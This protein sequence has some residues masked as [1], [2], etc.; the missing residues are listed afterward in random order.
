[1]NPPFCATLARLTTEDPAALLDHPDLLAVLADA[2]S[3]ARGPVAADIRSVFERSGT[4]GDRDRT[5]T[6]AL[7]RI[8]VHHRACTLG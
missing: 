1:M 4:R 3:L 5:A 6:R 8:L 2:Q 7:D